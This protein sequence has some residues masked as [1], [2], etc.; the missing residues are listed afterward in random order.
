MIRSRLVTAVGCL[1]AGLLVLPGACQ[2]SSVTV[3]F[4]ATALTGPLAGNSYIGS[5]SY[6][7][8]GLTGKGT[9]STPPTA[10]SFN[11]FQIYSLADTG[12]NFIP[13][14]LVNGKLY[15][16]AFLIDNTNS[17]SSGSPDSYITMNQ[18]IPEFL[19][20]FSTGGESFPNPDGTC[21]DTLNA[22]YSW[23]GHGNVTFSSVP[24]VTTTPEP[25]GPLPMLAYV[26]VLAAFLWMRRRR[27][28]C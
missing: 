21:P 22:C 8:S 27:A 6:D 18:G 15:S 26:S 1:I 9:E 4:R 14:T 13:I 5:F 7:N 12:G 25:A 20:G 23:E 3:D 11:F 10:Y 2:A 24:P 16:L 28:L 17:V 19:Y